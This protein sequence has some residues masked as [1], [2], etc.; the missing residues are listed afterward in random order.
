[1]AKKVYGVGVIGCGVIWQNAHMPGLKRMEGEAEIRMVYDTNVTMAEKAASATGGRSARKPEEL[2]SSKEIDIVAILTPPFA[3]AGYVE[4]ACAS[5]KHL[6]LEKPIAK[7]LEEALRICRMIRKAGI[8]CFVPF[9]RATRPSVGQAV[10]RVR[11]GSLGKPVAF[12]HTNASGPYS[13]VNFDHWIQ[14]QSLSGGPIVDFSIH[15]V[16][17]A[18]AALGRE[19]ESALYGGAPTTGRMKADDLATL[20]VFFPEDGL[21]EFTKAWAFPP[22]VKFSHECTYIVCSEGVVSLDPKGDGPF[23]WESR[24]LIHTAK[25]VEEID[26]SLPPIDGRAAAYRNL[27]AGIEGKAAL[28]ADEVDGLRANEI[29]DAGLRSRETGRREKVLSQTV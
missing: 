13:S 5:G 29:L 8:K 28:L 25:G 12:A 23:P 4:M 27:I 20:L 1:M 11:S 6:M 9:R 2:F 3:R 14:N 19:A 18:R 16:D 15:F 24:V 26:S 22:G 21:A 7:D 17:M 10:D